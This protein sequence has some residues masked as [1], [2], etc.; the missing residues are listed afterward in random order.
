MQEGVK[1]TQH[2]TSNNVGSCWS[3]ILRP[4][5]CSLSVGESG[6]GVKNAVSKV[7]A[8]VGTGRWLKQNKNNNG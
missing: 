5:A 7:S 6:L 8:F 3:T 2:V 4:F 1:R